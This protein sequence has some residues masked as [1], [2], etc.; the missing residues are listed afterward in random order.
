MTEHFG[1]PSSTHPLGRA[2]QQAVEEARE[3][4]ADLLGAQPDEVI[5][6][7]GGSEANNLALKGVLET[8]NGYRGHMVISAIEHPAIVEPVRFL[9]R[10]GCSVTVVPTNREGLIDP[11]MVEAALQADTVLVSIMHA[12]NEI[13]S[14]Q[15]LQQVSQFCRRRGILL[16]T[17]AAQSVGKIR[18]QVEEL[19]VDLLSLAGHKLY[20]PKGIGASMCDVVRTSDRSSTGQDKNK[21]YA[22]APRM[23][24]SSSDWEVLPVWPPAASTK[25]PSD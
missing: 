8:E 12:N 25:T 20:A 24:L 15:P 13:G 9:H 2:T 4:V 23:S 11:Q 18:V 21:D 16:H 19:G 14:I 5:F 7:S 17:D 3:Q 22:L 10:W 6:T 1:N